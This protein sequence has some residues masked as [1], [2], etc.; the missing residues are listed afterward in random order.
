M[1]STKRRLYLRILFHT[2]GVL[3]VA[4]SFLVL[5]TEVRSVRVEDWVCAE[6]TPHYA[7]VIEKRLG[8][9]N[10]YTFQNIS[11][12]SER[13]AE[14]CIGPID[15]DLP[16]SY[17]HPKQFA[18]AASWCLGLAVIAYGL[19]VVVMRRGDPLPRR[20][21]WGTCSRSVSWSPLLSSGER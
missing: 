20:R 21:L 19:T 3:A 5:N 9:P 6:R 10:W 8:A 2:L 4:L 18:Q 1:L 7:F 11:Y 13:G 15:V 12:W 16:A 14:R 17:I